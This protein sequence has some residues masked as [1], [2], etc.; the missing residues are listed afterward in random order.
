MFLAMPVKRARISWTAARGHLEVVKELFEF[1]TDSVAQTR[2]GKTASEIAIQEGHD[3]IA[4]FFQESG[5]K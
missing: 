3:D 1:G 5:G 4:T 2:K